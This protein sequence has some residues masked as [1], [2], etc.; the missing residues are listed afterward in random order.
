MPFILPC[1]GSELFRYRRLLTGLPL[2]GGKAI[3]LA[4]EPSPAACADAS[5]RQ[6]PRFR[7]YIVGNSE[8]I[9][10]G[11]R[12]ISITLIIRSMSDNA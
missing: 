9:P 6:R 11:W 5:R 10:G 7:T 8:A 3:T 12:N 1:R 2:T 4:C